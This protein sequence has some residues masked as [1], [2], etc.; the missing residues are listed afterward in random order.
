M[1]WTVHHGKI[2]IGVLSKGN[3]GFKPRY[4]E[5]KIFF[6]LGGAVS[7]PWMKLRIQT[8]K[9]VLCPAPEYLQEETLTS[10]TT[11]E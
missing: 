2:F 8:Y 5:F 4:N 6:V 11:G 3:I 10:Q 1:K 7:E 9:A